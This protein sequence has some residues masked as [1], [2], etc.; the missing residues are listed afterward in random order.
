MHQRNLAECSKILLKLSQISQPNMAQSV[1]E[2]LSNISELPK[3]LESD[4]FT[5]KEFIAVSAIAIRYTDPSK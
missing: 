4:S 1:L 5:D 2:L 3:L